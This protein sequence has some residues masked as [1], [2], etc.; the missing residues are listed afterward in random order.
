MSDMARLLLFQLKLYPDQADWKESR[1]LTNTVESDL[2]FAK[3]YED[4]YVAII[5]TIPSTSRVELPYK[6]KWESLEIDR[7]VFNELYLAINPKTS[8]PRE[9]LQRTLL[10]NGSEI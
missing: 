1:S 2:K 8:P 6:L 7:R 4:A 9:V 3:G 10:M 5:D